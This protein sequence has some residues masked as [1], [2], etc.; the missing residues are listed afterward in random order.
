[1][2]DSP[3]KFAK[4]KETITTEYTDPDFRAGNDVLPAESRG[5]CKGWK[6]P[7]ADSQAILPGNS[8]MAVRQGMIGDCYL[9]SAIGSLG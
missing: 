5:E 7:S 2:K 3:A 4:L 1:M 8:G 6:R 9:I